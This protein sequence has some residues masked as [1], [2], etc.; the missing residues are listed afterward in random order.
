MPTDL[1]CPNGKCPFRKLNSRETATNLKDCGNYGPKFCPQSRFPWH[2]NGE[3][4]KYPSKWEDRE[5]C[6]KVWVNNAEKY[7]YDIDAPNTEEDSEDEGVAVKE[8]VE[9]EWEDDTDE[10][11]DGSEDGEDGYFGR[12]SLEADKEHTAAEDDDGGDE[13]GGAQLN[14][15]EDDGDD[16]KEEDGYEIA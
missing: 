4:H 7:D 3:F 5:W 11:E 12:I 2:F 10:E 1:F 16:E 15:V 9:W 14:R 13:D 6:Y 8:K